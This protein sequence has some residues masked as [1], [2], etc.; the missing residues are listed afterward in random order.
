[1]KQ[2]INNPEIE[3]FWDLTKEPIRKA[4]QEFLR[5]WKQ[6]A[7]NIRKNIKSGYF[8]TTGEVSIPYH[9]PTGGLTDLIYGIYDQVEELYDPAA[10]R[11][12]TSTSEGREAARVVTNAYIK[13]AADLFPVS[14]RFDCALREGAENEEPYD[15][16]IVKTYRIAQY[17]AQRNRKDLSA[18]NKAELLRYLDGLSIEQIRSELEI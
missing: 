1:M 11:D 8:A 15:D 10:A 4:H 16:I 6:T 12:H 13:A 9:I 14:D 5:D 17:Q 18:M 2:Y 3:S 7:E